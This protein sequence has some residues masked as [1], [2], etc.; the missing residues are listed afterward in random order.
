MNQGTAPSPLSRLVDLQ[1]RARHAGSVDELSFL[2]VNDSLHLVAYRQ[3]ALWSSQQGVQALSGVVQVEANAP[4]V[5]W[6]QGLMAQCASTLTTHGPID[7]QT[8]PE[9]IRRA[10]SNW[11]PAHAFWLPLPATGE[12]AAGG[13]LLARELPWTSQEGA[14]L[15]EWLDSWS[16]ARQALSRPVRSSWLGLGPLLSRS[17]ASAPPPAGDPRSRAQPPW[18]RRTPVLGGALLLLCLLPVRLTVLAPG[19]LVP[20]NPDI[21][22]S[23][24]EGVI[25]T[26]HVQPN[27]AVRQGQALF[28][29]DEAILRSKLAVALQA[30]ATA[31]AEYRQTAQQTLSDPKARALLAPL[32]GSI[33]EKRAQAEYLNEQLARAQVLSPREGI[34]L[35][36]DPTEWI[37]RPVT[38]GERILRV[39][40]PEDVEVEAWVAVADAIPLQNA[41]A[42]TLYLNASPLSPVQARVRYLSHEALERPDG[43]FAYRLRATLSTPTDHRVG[44]KG[45]VRIS[46]RWVPLVY[47]VMRRPWAVVR[48]YIG[49]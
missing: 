25:A 32:S 15:A 36:D 38:V 43:T 33:E 9:D 2:L 35:F 37:G 45:T 40:R 27:D 6:L 42:V 17:P 22:R 44:L 30:L 29:F 13:W 47:W 21:I 19:E 1:R 49:W 4:Y 8:L 16:H 10:W 7:P 41:A 46:G 24:L 28:G 12:P 26:F 39:A 23:P 20:A 31:E 48:G 11:L 5:R 3:S 34:V 18:W 14:L